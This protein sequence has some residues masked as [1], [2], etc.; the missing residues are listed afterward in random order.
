MNESL[1]HLNQFIKDFNLKLPN[2]S[3]LFNAKVYFKEGSKTNS[4]TSDVEIIREENAATVYFMNTSIASEKLP[5]T[6]SLKSSNFAYIQKQYLK[7]QSNSNEL[8][9][10]VFPTL[11]S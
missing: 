8:I 3:V 7:I 10:S 9:I 1:L 5:D 2:G 11:R 4:Q 6:F